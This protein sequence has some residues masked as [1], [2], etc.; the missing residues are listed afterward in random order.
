[1]SDDSPP[2]PTSEMWRVLGFADVAELGGGKQSRVFAADGVEG[3]VAVKLTRRD[4]VDPTTV[5]QR[6][7]L[8][9]RLAQIHPAV[10]APISIHGSLVHPI[11][12]WLVTATELIDGSRL[13]ET[14]EADAIEMG[15]ELAALHRSFRHMPPVDLPLVATLRT[16]AAAALPDANGRQLVHGDFST[17]NLLRT[18]AGV[19]IFDFD[20]C[21]YGPAEFDVAN[22]L[23][24]DLFG[25]WAAAASLTPFR[26]F[27]THLLQGYRQ[28]G[29]DPL[30]LE[31]VDE[32]IGI[33][34]LALRD[35]VLDPSIA[36]IGIRTSTDGWLETLRQFTDEWLD[37]SSPVRDAVR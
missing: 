15:S 13:V 18:S 36:P 20:E 7:G 1:M 35:W 33:R 3:R 29:E 37:P 19:R 34:V 12:G 31:L 2:P 16:P 26:S 21:G 4:L 30:D 32:L 6:A 27:R 9:E 17:S 24:M 28:A 14:N 5:G 8:V 10:A 22:T 23:Y 25:R 11:D